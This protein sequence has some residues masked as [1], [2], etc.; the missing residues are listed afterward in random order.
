MLKSQVAARDVNDLLGRHILADGYDIVF[1][2]E[3]S[4]GG[5]VV[6][7]RDGKKY[8][9]FFNGVSSMPLGFNY[10]RLMQPEIIEYLG[11]LAVN[12]PANS[13]AYSTVL[14]EAVDAFMR[15][16]A[17]P[18]M[19]HVFF[20]EG[21][22]LAVENAIKAAMDWKVQKNIARGYT[23]DKYPD[24]HGTQVMHLSE[25][26]HGRSGYTL[27]MT[28]S[29]DPNKTKWFPKFKWPRITTPKASFPLNGENLEATKAR[30]AQ[31]IRE[32]EDAVAQNKDD[33]CCLV[34]EPIQGE[35]GD[36]HFRSEFIKELRRLADQ[37]EFMLIFDEVQ[38]GLGITGRMWAHE[39]FGVEP[40]M[41][42]FGKKTQVCGFMAGKRIDEIPTNVFQV[43]SRINST[44]G[45]NLIDFVRCRF[46]L[47]IIHEDGLV[48]N[49]SRLGDHLIG[50][51]GKMASSMDGVISNIR[52]KG[53][54]C[55]FDVDPRVD[56]HRVV[57]HAMD[58]GV[59]ILPSGRQSLRFRPALCMDRD[60]LEEGLTRLT[61]AFQ[62]AMQPA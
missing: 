21:G 19:K 7:E 15:L 35:G 55:A 6:D 28:D 8:V 1:D 17:P 59:I 39:H 44:W 12:K 45:G 41:I 32:I 30:E 43:S 54:F 5:W 10:P 4:S 14:A 52:G 25:C 29:P 47:Q 18:Y 50:Q 23:E 26:F 60:T 36:N 2:L 56:R 34:I 20:I 3:K 31:A 48:E 46:Y 53:L 62:K 42:V 16:A 57:R 58:E 13:D 38:T 51:L 9:D 22:A 11:R 33:I 27:S 24:G 37:R 49:A 40:D 61:R